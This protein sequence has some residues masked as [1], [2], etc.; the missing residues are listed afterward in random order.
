MNAILNPTGG[1][2]APTPAAGTA[3]P[4]TPAGSSEPAVE[5]TIT[6]RFNARHR[7]AGTG[8]PADGSTMST[9]T[10]TT[11]HVGSGVDVTHT[12][13]DEGHQFGVSIEGRVGGRAAPELSG[14]ATIQLDPSGTTVRSIEIRGGAQWTRTYL[15]NMLQV[16]PFVRMLVQAESAGTEVAATAPATLSPSATATAG[17]NA[18]LRIGSTTIRGSA[19]VAVEIPSHEVTTTFSAEVSQRIFGPLSVSARGERRDTFGA[20]DPS[21]RTTGTLGVTIGNPDGANLRLGG[22]IESTGGRTG[23]TGGATLTLPLPF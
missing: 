4:A 9:E 17:V 2:A 3:S 19:S 12:G 14:E 7:V 18:R 1:T 16:Q 22:G 15:N 10:E 23:V 11:G 20:G 6:T 8:G 21:S 13:S 5:A